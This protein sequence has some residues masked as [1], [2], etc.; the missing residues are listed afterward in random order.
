MG[1]NDVKMN[2]INISNTFL[3]ELDI[4]SIVFSPIFV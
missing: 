2:N 4:Q 3:T 1:N